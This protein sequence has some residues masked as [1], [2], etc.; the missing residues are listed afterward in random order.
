MKK[1][2]SDN[3]LLFLEL[4]LATLSNLRALNHALT[5]VPPGAAPLLLDFEELRDKGAP[6]TAP[7]IATRYILA[8]PSSGMMRIA[9]K[10]NEPKPC[11]SRADLEKIGI[12]TVEIEGFETG[13]MEVEG[14]GARPWFKA[15]RIRPVSAVNTTTQPAK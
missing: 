4:N 6:D 1:T 9:V 15:Q 5:T 14:G 3:P 2:P 8:F 10:V 12:V 13:L 7:Q 11:I